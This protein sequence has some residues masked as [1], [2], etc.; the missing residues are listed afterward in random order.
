M[1]IPETGYGSWADYRARRAVLRTAKKALAGVNCEHA[2]ARC[3]H[4]D[5]W[6]A[7]IGARRMAPAD[8]HYRARVARG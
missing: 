3:V 2:S 8:K 6:E 1:G 7:R 5:D 4:A